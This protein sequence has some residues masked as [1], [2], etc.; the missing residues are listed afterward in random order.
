MIYS[1]EIGSLWRIAEFVKLFYFANVVYLSIIP[2][3]ITNKDWLETTFLFWWNTAG[4]GKGMFRFAKW[5]AFKASRPSLCCSAGWR[6]EKQACFL[7]AAAPVPC[8]PETH[9]SQVTGPGKRDGCGRLE[10]RRTVCWAAAE[11]LWDAL[12]LAHRVIQTR[13]C[14]SSASH[15]RVYSP[16]PI[17]RL[18]HI[19]AMQPRKTCSAQQSW[20]LRTMFFDPLCI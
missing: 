4:S 14:S 12:M 15:P 8:M 20:H 9:Q 17:V 6:W 2:D 5:Y 19:S 13:A 18:V 11:L 1:I 10:L 3:F 7:K 16:L